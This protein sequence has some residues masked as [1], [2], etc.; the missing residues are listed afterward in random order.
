MKFQ[1]QGK[2]LQDDSGSQAAPPFISEC[3]VKIVYVD[4]GI[5]YCAS[6]LWNGILGFKDS[7]L[8]YPLPQIS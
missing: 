7:I 6:A 2:G 8:A 3:S 4:R 1:K 5:V